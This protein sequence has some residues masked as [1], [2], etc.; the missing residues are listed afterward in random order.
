[1]IISHHHQFIFI[2]IP[3][4]GTHAI[5]FVLRQHLKE[6]DEEQVGLFKQST[7]EHRIL[8]QIGHGHITALQA[9]EHLA[10]WNQYTSFS[11]VRN[12]YDR[13]VS[14]AH[15]FYGEHPVMQKHPT[16][17]LK[18]LLLFPPN[19]KILWFKPQVDFLCN[20]ENKLI[21]DIVGKVETIQEDYQ[22]I[23]SRLGLTAHPL[24]KVNTSSHQ[25]FQHYY[26]E[27]LAEM[28]YQY[29]EQDFLTFQYAK[30]SWKAST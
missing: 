12:P 27:Q 16:L 1:M 6:S 4:T 22:E 28:T 20:Q 21:V 9:K 19:K 14:F 13:L 24:S 29:Y 5:R 10:Y 2:A 8:S 17:H 15:Y 23:C 3:K 26:D 30:D 18:K 7:L 11:F 25:S